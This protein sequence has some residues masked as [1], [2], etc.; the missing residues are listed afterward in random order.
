MP[1]ACQVRKDHPGHAVV[2]AQWDLGEPKGFL[3]LGA[4]KVLGEAGEAQAPLALGVPG[5]R[6]HPDRKVRQVP[7]AVA[8]R[9]G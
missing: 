3:A 9:R 1:S 2:E 6:G 7:L 4:H 5:A 8:D